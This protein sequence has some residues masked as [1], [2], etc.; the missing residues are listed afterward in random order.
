MAL[1]DN[2]TIEKIT[3]SGG[4]TEFMLNAAEDFL[5]TRVKPELVVIDDPT[6]DPEPPIRCGRCNQPFM[7]DDK[8]KN[9]DLGDGHYAPVHD[10]GCPKTATEGMHSQ[11]DVMDKFKL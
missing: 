7:K 6:E 3:K 8:F 5:L 10:G 1:P 2:K 11:D 4:W 9:A